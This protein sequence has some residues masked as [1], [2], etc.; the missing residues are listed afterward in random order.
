[1]TQPFTTEDLFLHQKV[2]ELDAA[3]D[4][5]AV[6][7]TVRSVDRQQDQYISCIWCIAA[8]GSSPPRQLTRGPGQDQTPR[9]SPQGDR[10]AFVSTR[11]G[12]PRVHVLPRDGGEAEPLGQLPGA[13]SDM[14]WLPDG[15][16]LI[17]TAAVP[18]DVPEQLAG[19]RYEVAAG[20]VRRA[21]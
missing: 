8:D 19:G 16:A 10:L 1:M 11:G 3:P 15:K 2:Q 5:A 21:G 18:G 13:V 4:G 17:V 14:R 7:C 20:A 12:S 9:W 6:A